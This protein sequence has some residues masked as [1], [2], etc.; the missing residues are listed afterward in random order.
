[1]RSILRRMLRMISTPARFTPRSRVSARIVSSILQVLI[2]VQPRVAVGARR[3]QQPFA[4]VE[5]QRLRMDVVLRRHR[6]DHVVALAG[7]GAL[8]WH[9]D[10]SDSSRQTSAAAR[11]PSFSRPNSRSSSRDRSSRTGGSTICTSTDQ[12]SGARLAGSAARRARHA[13]RLTGD[14]P[15]GLAL[16]RPRRASAHRRGRR[17][18]L[19]A[20]PRAASRADR[21]PSRRKNGCGATSIVTYRSP[22]GPPRRPHGRAPARRRARRLDARREADGDDFAARLHAGA[23]AR[24]AR[25]ARSRARRRRTPRTSW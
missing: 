1:M 7:P 22:A 17:A 14:V 12:V 21:A 16:A 13:Q 11:R 19:R 6:A 25:L 9:G 23:A 24:P 10:L 20:P 15:A 3:L 2:R 8:A 5:P 4:L 18:P